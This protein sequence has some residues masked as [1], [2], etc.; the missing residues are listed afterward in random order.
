MPIMIVHP[1]LQK[2]DAYLALHKVASTSYAQFEDWYG[3]LVRGARKRA[4]RFNTY[5]LVLSTFIQDPLQ[6][7][8]L[9]HEL[10]ERLIN[11]PLKED[12]RPPAG[13]VT[14]TLNAIAGVQMRN[15]FEILE[16]SQRDK[17][18]YV[19]EP[20]F[21]FYLRWREERKNIT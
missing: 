12:R 15:G 16:W 21:L 19:L 20:T 17:A 9:R 1:R 7:S 5:E 4:R 13:S 10:D 14:S 6:F 3:R 18:L 8:L 11:I 2:Q